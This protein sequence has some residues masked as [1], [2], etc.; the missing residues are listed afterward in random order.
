MTPTLISEIVALPGWNTPMLLLLAKATLILIAAL[1]ITVAMQR[2]SAGARHLV[3]LVTLGTLLLVPAVATWAPLKLEILPPRTESQQP[4]AAPAVLPSAQI[5]VANEVAGS[6]LSNAA[7][8]PALSTPV[9]ATGPQAS[10]TSRISGFS[11]VFAIWLGVVLILAGWLAW[12]AVA[13]RRIVRN[14]HPLDTGDWLTPLYEVSDRLELGEPPTLLG[15]SDTK[16]PFACGFLKPTIVL[17][18]D[19]ESWTV[20]RR[21]AV[22]LHELAHVKRR[23]LVGHTLG[24]VACAVYWFHPLVWTAAKQLRNESERAC[25][26][27]ALSCGARAS[28]YAEHLLDI[29]TSVRHDSTPVVALAMARRKEFE[30]RMLA[31]LDPEL[32]HSTPSRKQSMA[33]IGSLALI[34]IVV[35]A[36]APA[37]RAAR[38]I[39]LTQDPV[40]TEKPAI[41][42][43]F[44][45]RD[46]PKEGDS[47]FDID[48]LDNSISK[49]VRKAVDKS[50]TTSTQQSVRTSVTEAINGAVTPGLLSSVGKAVGKAVGDAV[51]SAVANTGRIAVD[52]DDDGAAAQAV[53]RL[54]ALGGRVI[55]AKSAD[56][57]PVLLANILRTESDA[58]LRRIAAWGL[59]EYADTQ[60][61]VDALVNAL[62]KD[63]DAS[64]REMAAWALN[65]ANEGTGAAGALSAALRGDASERVRATSAWALGNLGDRDGVPALV[66]AL[67]DASK[68]V[69][70][71]A[72]WAIGQVEPR[73]VPS[74]AVSMLKDP[75]PEV[76][77]LAAWV[78]YQAEDPATAP[79]LNEALR[80]EQNK[81]L[82]IA[83]IRALAALGEKSVDAIRG[84][85]TSSDPKIKS[86]AIR[87]LAGGN[88]AGPWPWPWPEPRPFPLYAP[89]YRARRI[90]DA[91]VFLTGGADF[92]TYNSRT[93]QM[94]GATMTKVFGVIVAAVLL[95]TRTGGGTS[96][97]NLPEVSDDFFEVAAPSDVRSPIDINALLTAARGAPPI[98]CSLAAQ[99][100]RGWGW[101]DQGDA[102]ATPLPVMVSLR[103]YEGRD[104]QLA[105]ADVELLLSSLASEDPCVREISVRILGRKG[106]PATEAGLIS[107]LTSESPAMREVAALG[108]GLSEPASAIDPLIRA[109]RD[110]VANVRANAAWALGKMESGRALNPL[111]DM[112]RDNSETVRHAAVTAVGRLDSTRAVSTLIR[113][114]RQDE[115]PVVRRAAAW[116]LGQ[117]EAREAVDALTGVLT[118]DADPRVREMSAW[119]LGNIESRTAATA[120]LAAARRDADDKV[121]ET[122]VWALGQIEESTAADALA[123]IAVNDKSTRVRGT[124]AW[125][126]GQMRDDGGKAPSGLVQLLKDE[127]ADT[128]LKAAWALG[129]IGDSSMIQAIRDALKTER[130]EQVN[131]ALIRALLKS[132]ERSESA[133]SEL[134]DSK[135]PQVREAAVRGLAGRSS[136]NPWP[137]PWPRPRPFI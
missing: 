32:R 69:R 104:T 2:G 8:T 75:N 46:E 98:I 109:L 92:S 80:V 118:Q 19:C 85:L 96:D 106:T 15:S 47:V 54:N 58:A 55:T 22:L 76:R 27:L 16:M 131:K 93:S 83:Y 41:D 129:Q 78:M 57:R 114:V 17:P 102:P 79:A 61:A 72:L 84:L 12:G 105:A 74:Q 39:A 23:D 113:V 35:G 112:F 14:A 21:H 25:D 97:V 119:A 11:L 38:D 120:L 81:D 99:S 68:G 20:D 51:G 9:S 111:L 30:G 60:V 36:A 134:L 135:D 90:T 136:F 62:R 6:A 67:S 48:R 115:S 110:Q 82:Q 128:R 122:A 65:D 63:S 132:G 44:T 4:V 43:D 18:A 91:P 108:I 124:A 52:T 13:V 42:K 29:V 64:V 100:L 56:D 121:R 49:S 130:N 3:W 34:A 40:T 5:N 123:Q 26:D 137:W 125:A 89:E 24:R 116:A 71:R 94:K 107:R 103:D 77:E 117:L 133:L 86:M 1:G 28:D 45:P 7:I 126:I 87:A 37:P 127:S 10:V 101:G 59:S 95:S 73:Q 31:I 53:Q 88:A 33:L 66:A 70:M 50:V